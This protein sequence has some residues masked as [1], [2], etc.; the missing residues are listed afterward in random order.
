MCKGRKHNCL[1]T[2]HLRPSVCPKAL[3]LHPIPT[4]WK[5]HSSNPFCTNTALTTL[6]AANA[7][8]IEQIGYNLGFLL[9]LSLLCLV[10][11]HTFFGW[12][13]GDCL[14]E[15]LPNLSR[16]DSLGALFRFL[17]H[18]VTMITHSK[19]MMDTTCSK[20]ECLTYFSHTPTHTHTHTHK[21]TQAH[22]HSNWLYLRPCPSRDIPLNN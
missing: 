11:P 3:D 7:Y 19:S 22:Q 12:T 6:D 15:I 18:M 4:K 16:L 8:G 10:T 20:H 13:F 2:S 17:L 5:K 1:S 9:L 21:L 14:S